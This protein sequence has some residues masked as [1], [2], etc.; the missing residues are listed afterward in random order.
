MLPSVI[1]Q[2]EERD[3][4][5]LNGA[6]NGLEAAIRTTFLWQGSAGVALR[7]QHRGGDQRSAFGERDAEVAPDRCFRGAL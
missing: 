5:E 6:L 3:L 7:A 2:F 4:G 1:C